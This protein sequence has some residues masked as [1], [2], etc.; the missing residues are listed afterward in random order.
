M[1][2]HKLDSV[3]GV[4]L[5]DNIFFKHTGRGLRQITRNDVLRL[6]R[7]ELYKKVGGISLVTTEY[8]KKSKSISGGKLGY[9]QMP[10]IADI[11]VNNDIDWT[12]AESIVENFLKNNTNM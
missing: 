11:A 6:E 9:I 5:D 12:M 10:K 1:K 7:D 3:I 8:F 4:R 2:I